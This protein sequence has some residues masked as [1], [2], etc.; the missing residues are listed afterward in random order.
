MRRLFQIFFFYVLV[1][2][3]RIV[4]LFFYSFL[5]WLRCTCMHKD[6]ISQVAMIECLSHNTKN[7]WTKFLDGTVKFNILIFVVKTNRLI[8]RKLRNENRKKTT[9]LAKLSWKY[10]RIQPLLPEKKAKN[11]RVY[12]ICLKSCLCT[13]FAKKW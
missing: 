12:Q 8:A 1:E 7:I 5:L 9:A 11:T 3:S 6:N 4:F 13:I 2:Y 10:D